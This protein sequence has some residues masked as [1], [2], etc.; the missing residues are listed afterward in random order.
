MSSAVKPASNEGLDGESE[1]RE[2]ACGSQTPEGDNSSGGG[3]DGSVHRSVARTCVRE[4]DM[5]ISRIHAKKKKMGALE[6][7]SQSS[8]GGLVFG[9]RPFFKS[10]LVNVQSFTF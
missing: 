1:G 2:A 10:R 4:S 7:Q 8:E 6:L 5:E 9:I 3:R